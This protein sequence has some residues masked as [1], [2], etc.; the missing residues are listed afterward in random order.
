LN[1]FETYINGLV[2]PIYE[3]LTFYPRE[4]DTHIDTLNRVQVLTWLC[5]HKHEECIK[6][7]KE[8]FTK[9]K[10]SSGNYAINANIRVPVYCTAIREGSADDF[11]FLWNKYVNSNVAHE[12]VTILQA[13]GCAMSV[14]ELE[15]YL[16]N[17]LTDAIR[18][19][20]KNTCFGNAYNGNHE[21]VDTVLNY[22]IKNWVRWETN[23]M[24]SVASSIS[25]LSARFTREDQAAKVEKFANDEEVA[26]GKPK[27]DSLKATAARARTLMEWDRRRLGEVREFMRQKRGAAA[28]ISASLTLLVAVMISYAYLNL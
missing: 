13:L 4:S 10:Q 12:Q 26:L 18:P 14:P 6:N 27:V 8:E 15:K 19:Q 5:R 20:D 1:D 22:L 16:D 24:T 28:S 2:T 21:N 7:S 17:I 25:T 9:L 23:M 3:H 11:N